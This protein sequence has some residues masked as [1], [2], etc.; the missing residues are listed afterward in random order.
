MGYNISVRADCF[1][2]AEEAEWGPDR[3]IQNYKKHR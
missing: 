3:S 1:P 2:G